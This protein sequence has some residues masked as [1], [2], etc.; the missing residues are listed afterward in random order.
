MIGDYDLML[1]QG[2]KLVE[3]D[4]DFYGG[5]LVLGCQKWA[6]GN[7][8]EAAS[9]LKITVSQNYGSFTLSFL[10]CL[11]GTMGDE[12]KAKETLDE[13]I[14]ISNHQHVGN[15][16]IGFVYVGM[17]EKDEAIKWLE[18]AV[19]K[20]EGM[21]VKLKQFAKFISWFNTDPRIQA[22]FKKIGL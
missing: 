6:M 17:G 1:E 9:E 3:F 11:Y 10:G 22:L 16:D 7:F 20:H 2:K 14:E 19:E 12:V 8:E 15:F 4:P 18:R 5:H 21:C 13:I